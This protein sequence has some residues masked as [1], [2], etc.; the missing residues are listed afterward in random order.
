MDFSPFP[1]SEKHLSLGGSS[2]EETPFGRDVRVYR[3][4]HQTNVC[5]LS[6]DR[7]DD[8]HVSHLLGGSSSL[9]LPIS[10]PAV[11]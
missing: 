5:T 9:S 3:Q 7:G 6:L 4:P 2:Q 11:C 10:S 1:L 8:L